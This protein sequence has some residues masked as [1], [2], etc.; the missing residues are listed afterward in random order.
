MAASTSPTKA[1][2]ESTDSAPLTRAARKVKLQ[3][4]IID[5]ALLLTERH[6]IDGWTMQ[7]LASELGW[8]VGAAYR[9]LTGKDA[10]VESMAHEVLQRVRIPEPGQLDWEDRLRDLAWST[11]W[12]LSK[13]RWVARYILSHP[14]TTSFANRLFGA[15]LV[16][17]FAEAGYALDTVS[18]PIGLYAAFMFGSLSGFE[19][20]VAATSGSRSKHVRSRKIKGYGADEHFEWGLNALVIAVQAGGE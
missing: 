8:S 16:Q 5:A 10:I 2:T 3:Q 11:W 13:Q 7:M 20:E 6:G 14:E 15:P 12:Q 18:L 4:G 9:H 17:I 19:A 1:G